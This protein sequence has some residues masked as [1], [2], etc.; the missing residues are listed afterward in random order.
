MCPRNL[1]SQRPF[2]PDG[3][4]ENGL[5]HIQQAART[6]GGAEP[7]TPCPRAHLLEPALFSEH[8]ENRMARLNSARA[9]VRILV[10]I[11]SRSLDA[12]SQ[13]SGRM[14]DLVTSRIRQ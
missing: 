8:S 11:G 9:G 13:W 10:I 14:S 12:L 6:A 4:D 7:P 3:T 2:R 1:L 5:P